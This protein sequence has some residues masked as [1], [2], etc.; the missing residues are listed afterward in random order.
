MKKMIAVVVIGWG[1]AWG[2]AQAD[3]F[4]DGVELGMALCKQRLTFAL[5]G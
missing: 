2:G 5:R 4:G 3:D 1:L